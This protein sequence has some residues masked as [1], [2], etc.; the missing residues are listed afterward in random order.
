[1]KVVIMPA[2]VAQYQSLL[3]GITLFH[4]AP[5]LIGDELTWQ[6]VD[7][8]YDL[9][10]CTTVMIPLDLSMRLSEM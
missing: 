10:L 8:A 5:L 3:L 9:V 1:M 4:N 6:I 7:M 2:K